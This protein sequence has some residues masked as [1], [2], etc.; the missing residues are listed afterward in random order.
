MSSTKVTKKEVKELSTPDVTLNEAYNDEG[1]PLY[2]KFLQVSK[3]DKL[4]IT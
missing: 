4:G 2:V 1:E 3:I